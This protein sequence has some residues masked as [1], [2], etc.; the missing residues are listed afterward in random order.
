MLFFVKIWLAWDFL[1]LYFP[2][3]VFLNRFAAALLVLILGIIPLLKKNITNYKKIEKVAYAATA[4]Y[5]TILY[6][7][8]SIMVQVYDLGKTIL[9]WGQAAWL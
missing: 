3:P 1:N 4:A 6:I 9:I 2:D 8:D 5:T 7:M